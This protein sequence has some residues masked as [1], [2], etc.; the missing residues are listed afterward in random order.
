M[1]NKVSSNYLRIVA[2]VLLLFNGLSALVAGYG[3]M[4]DPSGKGLG[5]TT[6]YLKYP[7]FSDFFIPGV[8]LFTVN[9]IF[10]IILVVTVLMKTKYYPLLILF[11][12]IILSGW[13]IVQLLLV[14]YWYPL[15]GVML[16]VGVILSLI[17]FY[18]YKKE[19]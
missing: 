9:G 11:Q 8:I 7:V 4:I 14:K 16:A 18:L 5:M 10:S 6:E 13:I 2:L 12:G 17:G 1:R 19:N 15:H 3:F